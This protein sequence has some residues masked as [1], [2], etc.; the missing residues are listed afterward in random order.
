MRRSLIPIATFALMTISSLAQSPL[1]RAVTLTREKRYAEAHK[2]LQ[3]VT[4]PA[5]TAQRIAFHRLKAAIASGLGD[6]KI[7]AGE[8]RHAL[9]LAPAD[10]GLLLA[11]AIA[12][13]QAGL[14]DDALQ[15]ARSAG[16]TAQAQAVVGDIQEKRGEFVEAAKAYQGAVALAPDREQYRIALALELVEHQSFTP[17]IAVLQQAAPLFPKS[18]KLRTL[19]GIAQ[20]GE[21]DAAGAEK[22]LAEAI[23]ADPKLEP[24]YA[25]LSHLA[26]ES[27]AAPPDEVLKALCNW[28]PTVCSAMKLRLARE[29]DDAKLRGEAIAGL[30][31]AP[32]NDP[33]ARCEL[34]RAYEWTEQFAA[35]R[36]Q[37]EECVRLEPSPQNHYRLGLIYRQL[38]LTQL[39][40]QEMALRKKAMDNMSED[41]ARR[42]QAL[43]TFQFVIK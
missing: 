7:A 33:V 13:L 9:E 21:G 32:P 3:G 38:G 37:M 40:D 43:Q 39:A 26:L 10:S 29:R 35:A 18:G 2:L 25:Y 19:L 8:I 34:G 23:A 24:A 41:A 17:A 36:T 14:L 27:S 1:E 4:E 6:S 22:S 28:N 5:D 30:K 12:E 20:Y 15:H 42:A 16:A 11:T 31:R